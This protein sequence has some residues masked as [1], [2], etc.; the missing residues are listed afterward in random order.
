MSALYLSRRLGIGPIEALERVATVV[1]YS[2][3]NHELGALLEGD[4][5]CTNTPHDL[6]LHGRDLVA[7]TDHLA[8]R[9]HRGQTDKVGAPDSEHPRRV[10]E[11]LSDAD[12]RAG[13][14]LHDVL[15]DTD[16]AVGDL[17]AAGVGE[18][19]IELVGAA[20][21]RAD[22]DYEQGFRRPAAHPLARQLK[23]ADLQ[24]NSDPARLGRLDDTTARRLRSKY[25]AAFEILDKEGDRSSGL[26]QE[27]A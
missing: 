22:E 12:L 18:L 13:G 3:H 19:V 5:V 21:K 26:D 15:E 27:W 1:S 17:R 9:A 4:A 23:R 25:R 14:L 8:E 16:L 24:D 6:Q 20:T 2:P 11:R 10:A 7:A